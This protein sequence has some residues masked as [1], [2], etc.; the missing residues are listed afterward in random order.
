MNARLVAALRA[1]PRPDPAVAAL[2][3]GALAL[4]ALDP[5]QTGA[6]L[7]FVLASL[8]DLAPL[9][10]VAVAL[11]AGLRAGGTDA[12]I[13]R[14]LS[15]HETAMILLASLLGALSPLCSCGVVPLIAAL[16]AA[17]V[18]LAPVMAFWLS[19]P[20]IDPPTFLLTWSVLGLDFAL[21]KTAAAFLIGLTGGLAL[22][23]FRR[24]A[25]V[26]LPL[27]ST[28][29]ATG[30][31]AGSR[32]GNPE[33]RF[34]RTAAGRQRFLR[35]S[36]EDALLL[37]RWLALAF[38]I[39]SLMIA[40][41]PAELV[42]TAVGGGGWGSVVLATLA[43]VPAYLN[44]YAALPVVAGLLAKGMAPGAALAFL[45]AGGVT[46]IPAAA[47][48]AAIARPAVFAAYL[49]FALAGSLAAGFVFGLLAV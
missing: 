39:E 4:L 30:C 36:L 37:A 29:C 5:R 17:G 43:G 40:W 35:F 20:V 23:P 38:F 32:C 28:A 19:S 9:L 22:L 2:V 11:S 6:S 27:R 8:L 42:A 18:P 47:A 12:L 46:S 3:L 33:W 49:L 24:R 13:R 10:L 7:R 48:V 45:V 26:R 14:T 15:G 41:L 21:G 16:L 1:H 44:G 25:W 34:W 31:C